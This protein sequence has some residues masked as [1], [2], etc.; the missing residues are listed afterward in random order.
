MVW[1]QKA[2]TVVMVNDEEKEKPVRLAIMGGE[3][4]VAK[5]SAI[6]KFSTRF[7]NQPSALLHRKLV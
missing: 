5:R 1:D 7:P 4:I 2:H 3:E 6:T